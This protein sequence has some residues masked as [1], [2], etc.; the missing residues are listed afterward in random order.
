MI[1]GERIRLRAPERDD[2]ALFA[3]WINDPEVRFGISLY[4]PMSIAR[5]EQWFESMLKRPPDEHPLT[6]EVREGEGWTAIG[7]V[8]F[9]GLDPVAHSAEVGIMIGNKAYWNQGYGTEAMELILKHG[10]ETLNLHRIFLRV[11]ERNPRAIRCYEK[12]GYTHE[13]RLREAVYIDGEY[14]DMLVMGI[15]RRE[16]DKRTTD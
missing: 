14:S 12:A 11:F 8:G 15:L 4:L 10:F 3:A 1:Y 16:W 5:E 13:G 9:I 2:V 6:I 7:N